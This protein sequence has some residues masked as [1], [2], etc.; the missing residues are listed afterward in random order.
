MGDRYKIL[1]TIKSPQDLKKLSEK[2]ITSLCSEIREK[3]I[4]IVSVNGGHL[5][6]N[7]GV[8]E[9]TVVFSRVDVERDFEVVAYLD[10]EL[11]EVVV[12]EDGEGDPGW[13]LAGV[14]FDDI[15]A[16]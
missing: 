8:V 11:A 13:E 6:P 10:V 9:L 5:A 4:E 2:E 14:L 3:L 16:C 15:V 7:L 12:T 1:S